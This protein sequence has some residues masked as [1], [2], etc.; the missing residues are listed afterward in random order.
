MSELYL[1][2]SANA[3]CIWFFRNGNFRFTLLDSISDSLLSM[4]MF[5]YSQMQFVKTSGRNFW[6]LASKLSTYVNNLHRFEY[7][8]TV[9]PPHTI[10]S[11]TVF[12]NYC[13]RQIIDNYNRTQNF[14]KIFFVNVYF[15]KDNFAAYDFYTKCVTWQ[16]SLKNVF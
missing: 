14:S 2:A 1:R 5:K 11:L 6:S 4:S 9:K 10:F 8:F 7:F 13:T 15:I 3:N 12:Q 16:L